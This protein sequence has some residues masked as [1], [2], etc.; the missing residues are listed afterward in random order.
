[1]IFDA[2]VIGSGF[3]GAVSACRLAETGHRV[4]VLERGRRW[5]P[6]DYPR[7][8]D[9]DWIFDIDEPEEQNGWIDLRFLDD[10]W[11]AQGAGVGGGSLIYA[12]VSIDAPKAAFESGWPSQI[13]F[14]GMKP[15]YDRVVAMLKPEV[16]PDNQLTP[17]YKLMRD[18][19]IAIGEES[20]L[21]KVELA[22]S[23]DPDGSFPEQ[24]PA[25]ETATRN[26]TNAFG[27]QQG[28]CVHAGN[29][30]IG[31]KAQAK[32]TLDLNY[33]AVA[34]K[35]GAEIRP[36][37]MVS[38]IV[39]EGSRYVVVYHE[40]GN[41]ERRER[42]VRARNVF[43]AAGSLG[44]TELLF[45][46]RDLFSSLPKVSPALGRG[47][48]SN[49]DFL[50]PAF[51]ANRTLSPTLGPTIT[52]AID[53]LDGK[54]GG[55]RYFVEDGGFPDVL[56]NAIR[57]GAKQG[58]LR[59][60]S[61]FLKMLARLAYDGDTLENVMPWFGQAIDGA[62][63]QLYYGRDWLRPWRRRLKLDWD[64]KRSERGVGGLVAAHEK[65]SGAT[66]GSPKVPA[67]WTVLRNLITPHPLGGCGMAASSSAG[68]VN[69]AGEVFGYPGLY[70][71]DG[72][73]VPRPIGLNPSKTIAA[74]AERTL[75]LMLQK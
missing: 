57:A 9:D 1:M 22:V 47:W 7:G 35:E 36:L 26:F 74:L 68:V 34:E 75:E 6:N 65:L 71:V 33:L 59:P 58:R 69:H 56:G 45:R 27:M 52:A 8:P 4:L 13:T 23:F 2:I 31:C 5:N 72:A 64:V 37:S 55:A 70:V 60:G 67:T 49:G 16:L 53:F 63:G 62:D 39:A 10:I 41:G 54:D 61:G 73:V 50:T 43:L 14:G 25:A 28:Y 40:I 30:D 11:V 46:S 18:A 51:Y 42:I 44:S 32:N 66:G 3:G 48:S 17:R 20:R 21:R 19:A 29:C 24:R 12:N 15:Y 38:H